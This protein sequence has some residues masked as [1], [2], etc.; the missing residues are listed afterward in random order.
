MVQFLLHN[1]LGAWWAG[2]RLAAEPELA[3]IA[4]DEPALRA[5][6][7]LPGVDWA[8]LR[9]VRE[10][11]IW[12]PA[13]GTFPGWPG[14]AAEITV[15]DPCCGSGHFLVEALG[16]LAAL[17]S[18]EEGLAPAEAVRAVLRDNLFGL[19]ID[20]RCVQIAAFAVAV[21]AWR[22]AGEAVDL[23][24]PHI[25]WVGQAPAVSKSEWLR[26]AEAIA[27]T[28]PAPPKRDL[29]GAEENLF[30][31]PDRWA[32]ELLWGLFGQAPIL[33]S[34]LDV[35]AVPPLFADRLAGFEAA[36]A[37]AAFGESETN[38]L[39]LAARGMTDAAGMLAR[40]YILQAT[41]VPFLAI[42]KT[43]EEL[44]AFVEG[45]FALAGN[46]LAIA[47]LL[48]ML[49]LTSVGGTIAAVTPQN[50]YFLGS[51]RKVRE[52]L[53]AN[54][55]LNVICDLGPAAFHDMNWWAS[56]TAL[57]IVS[58]RKIEQDACILA[59]DA[60]A[61][62]DPAIKEK[63]VREAC[64]R[65]LRQ[66][67]QSTNPDARFTT[68]ELLEAAPLSRF[69]SSF[70]G[71]KTGD[72][73]RYRSLFWEGD[74]GQVGWRLYQS[75]VEQTM[76]YGGCEYRL[77]WE[78]DGSDLARR[79]GLGA[80][81]NLG[82]AISQMRHLP[83]SLYTGAA[84]DSNVSPIVPASLEIM[85][86][87]WA[88][89]SSDEY[90]D[91]IRKIDRK[92]AVA[93]GTLVKVPFDFAYWRKIAAQR[94]PNG[95]P[96]PYSDDPTQW[97]FHG[98][99]AKAE[100]GATLHVALARLAGYCWPAENDTELRLADEAKVWIARATVLPASDADGILCLPPVGGEV[101][102]AERLRA[103]LTA[104]YGPAW[105][106]DLERRL[107]AEAA[108][109]FKERPPADLEEWLRL[110]FF[111]QHCA[112]FHQ[113][114]FLWQVW[115]GQNDG[116]AAVLHYHRLTKANL[117]KLTYTVLGDWLARMKDL[118]DAR[119]LEAARILQQKLELILTGEA[120]YDIFVRWKPR[121]RLPLGWDPDLDDGVR[122]NIRPFVTAGI[123][124]ERPNIHWRKDRG[125]DVAT[126][127]WYHL[128]PH[129]GGK[130]GDRIN[131]HHT[132]LAEKQAAREAASAS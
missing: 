14:Q 68:E 113:R 23:P 25:A 19:E 94:Y 130:P 82:V 13:A 119:R 104:A 103:H 28:G 39:A 67:K 124:R 58:N 53:L 69:A 32:L 15:M 10:D 105:S 112:L 106:A 131:D 46:D 65:M 37:K 50:W 55:S 83:A 87:L 121:A 101:S 115:D 77:R 90:H 102:L 24:R 34:L 35:G 57:T 72:D 36:L 42:G 86:A 6:V 54:T 98:H 64:A 41:N 84:F 91:N 5:A 120:P 80:F 96:E 29:L 66:S 3:R 17:R 88:Y 128:G 107:L 75:T 110:R 129:Y 97:L 56:R 1:T 2:K 52:N 7:G 26:L 38:E 30:S 126:A 85:P 11:G 74:S 125:T 20:G 12:R 63:S 43:T 31:S 48:R 4:A 70:Q 8:Y 45:R 127:P 33:G 89:C 40:R 60:E 81:D 122:I 27:A 49:E 114:P 116:F 16:I 9:F 92:V 73:E 22:I 117:Q 62:R 123:L 71:I 59:I 61:G 47:M 18:A 76:P 118:G 93:N 44:R 79:Q 95:L 21:A 99:P 78:A 100:S 109:Q 132:T 108:E 51:F 111:R